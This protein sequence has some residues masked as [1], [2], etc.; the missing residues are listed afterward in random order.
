MTDTTEIR[1]MGLAGTSI[2]DHLVEAC[3]YSSDRIDP[4]DQAAFI[5]EHLWDH[6]IVITRARS[7]LK[8]L[9]ARAITWGA[10]GW[11]LNSAI[12]NLNDDFIGA[13]GITFFL[14]ILVITITWAYRNHTAS[15][16]QP[17]D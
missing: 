9:A 15:I 4:F 14:I 17:F 11:G 12:T 2:G 3:A 1:R 7:S 16:P 8:F 13:S 10:F 5:A 6:G